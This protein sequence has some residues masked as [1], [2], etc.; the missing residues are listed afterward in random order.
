[1]RLLTLCLHRYSLGS[2]TIPIES[3]AFFV[4]FFVL[5]L[6]CSLTAFMTWIMYSLHSTITDLGARRQKYKRTSESH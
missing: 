3:S 6:S 1:M 4:L 5:P 2:V